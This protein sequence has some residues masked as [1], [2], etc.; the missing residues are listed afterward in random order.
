MR[1]NYAAGRIGRIMALSAAWRANPADT[2][3]VERS[4][5]EFFLGRNPAMAAKLD[6]L[7]AEPGF[8]FVAIGAGHLLGEQGV[9][10]Q[11]LRR[12]WTITPCPDDRC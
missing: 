10:A 8:H 5:T 1:D 9:P 7:F 6:A 11:L 3:L 4:Y 12:G 2:A